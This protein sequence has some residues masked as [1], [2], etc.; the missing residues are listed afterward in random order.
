MQL[1]AIH[2]GNSISVWDATRHTNYLCSECC[3]PLRL[4]GGPI[5]QLHFYHLKAPRSCTQHQKSL[6]HIA[7]QH[8]L[9]TLLPPGEVQLERAFPD[10]HRIA[11]VVWEKQ[12]CVFEIQCSPISLYEARQRTEDYRTIGFTVIWI[13]HDRTFN[14]RTLTPSEA[15]LRQMPCYYTNLGPNNQWFFYD[16]FDATQN[17]KRFFWG[18]P[19]RVDLTKPQIIPQL[20]RDPPPRIVQRA[21]HASLYFTGDLLDRFLRGEYPAHYASRG[22]PPT[23]SRWREACRAA[24]NWLLHDCCS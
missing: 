24:F 7:I 20:E 15:Y 17:H 1:T 12:R 11:D 19:L 6:T 5:R 18:R 2:A 14:K 3:T 8:T 4:R 16:Q 21:H 9:H 10:I 23:R 22:S 13:L